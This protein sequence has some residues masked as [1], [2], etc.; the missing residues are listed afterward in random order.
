MVEAGMAEE[1]SHDHCTMTIPQSKLNANDSVS[2]VVL[3]SDYAVL[4][5]EELGRNPIVDD[6][7]AFDLHP[8]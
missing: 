3:T 6:E 5:A 1:A 7:A 8:S 2:H 4:L